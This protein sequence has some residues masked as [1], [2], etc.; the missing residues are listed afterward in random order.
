MM[1]L[2]FFPSRTLTLYLAKMFVVRIFAVLVMLVLVLMML[3]LLSRSGEILAEDRGGLIRAPRDG[4]IML[5]LYQGKGDDGFFLAR[6]VAKFWLKLSAGLRLLRLE[7][8]LPW[9][10]GVRRLEG[11]DG[12]LLVD[13]RVARWYSLQ[14]FHLLGYRKRRAQGKALI[15]SRRRHDLR[16]PDQVRLDRD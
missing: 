13:Q 3:D 2:D 10:P 9:L 15:V 16:G 12:R 8:I 7:R 4:R 14:I 5:P 1:Q 6:R 11:Q